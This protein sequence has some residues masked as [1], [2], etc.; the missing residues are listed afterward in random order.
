[1]S[2]HIPWPWTES[3][4]ALR[5]DGA[6]RVRVKKIL[7]GL[8]RDRCLEAGLEEGLELRCRSR[9]PAQVVFE[10]PGGQLRDLELPYAWFVQVEPLVEEPVQ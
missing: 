2:G 9:S 6:E 4:G 1:M 10:L 8:V 5:P 3:L 7:S